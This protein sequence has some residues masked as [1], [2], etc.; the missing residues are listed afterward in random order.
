MHLF[1][2]AVTFD[3]KVRL[4]MGT[5]GGSKRLVLIVCIWH[6]IRSCTEM[7]FD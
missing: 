6:S 5:A 7:D 4:E 3:L 2:A 1:R